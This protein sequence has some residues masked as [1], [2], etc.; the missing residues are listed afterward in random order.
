[1]DPFL[2]DTCKQTVWHASFKGASSDGRGSPSF[3]DPI[4]YPARIEPEVV[5]VVAPSGETVTTTHRI[6]T[7]AQIV[8]DDDRIWITDPSAGGRARRI[9]RRRE[10]PDEYGAFH[11]S[12]ILI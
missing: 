9:A 5:N 7:S 3:N 11:H 6:I 12:E 2:L 1:M 10:L 4:S 8:T